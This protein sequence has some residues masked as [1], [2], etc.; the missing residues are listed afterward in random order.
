MEMSNVTKFTST[1]AF[2]FMIALNPEG[3]ALMT[4]DMELIRKI[5]IEI[6]KRKDARP[7]SLE[8]EG[9]DEAIVGRHLEMLLNSGLIEGQNPGIVERGFPVILVKDLSWEGHDFAAA[10]LNDNVWSKL[11]KAFSV[12]DLA[13]LPLTV[14]KSVG[15]DLLMQLA[16]AQVGL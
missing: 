6:R 10:L 4:R 1:A 2:P 5:F 16:K 3:R 9:V 8:I 12:A 15:A 7:S 11:K 14:L 13:T